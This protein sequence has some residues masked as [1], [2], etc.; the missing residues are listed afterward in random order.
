M[1]D[2][3]VKMVRKPKPIDLVEEYIS[4][5]DDRKNAE[6]KMKAWF[7]E[8]YDSRM[9]AIEQ[10]LLETLDELGVDKLAAKSGTVYKM[11]MTSVTTADPREFRRHIVGEQAWDLVDWRPNKT[12]I[13]EL[14]AQ[15][16]PVPPGLN[17][18][19]FYRI[20]IRKGKV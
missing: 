6:E 5:R 18:T 7:H 8:H 13:K 17:Y 19:P 1:S 12:Q 9:V 20:G 4:L 3:V 2:N 15:G 11:Q 10:Q 14:V 16:E